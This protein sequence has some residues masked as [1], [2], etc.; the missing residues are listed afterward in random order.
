M[1]RKS[2]IVI[3]IAIFIILLALV[4]LEKNKQISHGKKDGVCVMTDPVGDYDSD[5]DCVEYFERLKQDAIKN[6]QNKKEDTLICKNK[7]GKEMSFKQALAIAQNSPVCMKEGRI[8]ET[9]S[10]SRESHYCGAFPDFVAIPLQVDDAQG[11]DPHCLVNIETYETEI[12]WM[13]TGLVDKNSQPKENSS[14]IPFGPGHPLYDPTPLQ[15][16][17]DAKRMKK[18]DLF[19]AHV[20]LPDTWNVV[21]K[22]NMVPGG[23]ISVESY[24]L[25]PPASLGTNNNDVIIINSKRENSSSYPGDDFLHHVLLAFHY[26][27]GLLRPVPMYT[28]SSDGY[29]ME[30]FDDIQRQVGVVEDLRDDAIT[31]RKIF[32]TIISFSDDF[33]FEEGITRPDNK[34]FYALKPKDFE[35]YKPADVIFIKNYDKN[36]CEEQF[37]HWPHQSCFVTAWDNCDTNTFGHNTHFGDPKHSF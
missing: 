18:V 33:D 25:Y 24:T 20:D 32:N 5:P 4:F 35:Q 22:K 2:I 8:K 10:L 3:I 30:V 31:S 36:T 9:G 15:M 34:K 17:K 11:C 12:N 1:K 6:N 13:C 37:P 14:E 27:S 19:G 28:N 29:V 23:G 16:Q 26:S 7:S 21:E